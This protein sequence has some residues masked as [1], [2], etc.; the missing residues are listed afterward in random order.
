MYKLAYETTDDVSL[1]AL[2][3]SK[4]VIMN[5][6]YIVYKYIFELD[7]SKT[8]EIQLCLDVNNLDISVSSPIEKLPYWTK[9]SCCK[10]PNCP[11]DINFYSYCPIAVNIL[12]LA[13]SFNDFVSY[14]KASVYV[15]TNSRF[16]SKQTDLQ[17][18]LSS[19]LGVYMVTSGCP[20]M[21]KLRPMV[22]FHLPFSSYAETQYRAISMYLTGQYLRYKKGKE[23]DWDLV[24]FV[25]MY[26][27]I[28][29][30]NRA[31]SERL[32][33][34]NR[35]NANAFALVI[36]DSFA[37]LITLDAEVN[38]NIPEELES[39]FKRFLDEP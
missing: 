35:S 20:I 18:A 37:S 39:M 27:E 7:Q 21:D 2:V 34:V 14:Q 28:K 17:T 11:L 31:F 36:L 16:Y 9:L 29:K 19:I 1:S 4:L 13:N 15:E 5:E 30:V 33:Q 12:T 32:Q 23:P 6:N 24:G 25:K 26:E 38:E 22:R 10:C 8:K 3:R